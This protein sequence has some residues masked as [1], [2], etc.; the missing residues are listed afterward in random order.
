MPMFSNSASFVKQ[1][2]PLVRDNLTMLCYHDRVRGVGPVVAT[3]R[4]MTKDT[5]SRTTRAALLN[6]RVRDAARSS[7]TWTVHAGAR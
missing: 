3:K 5:A 6:F 2:V 4:S 7:A 1:T